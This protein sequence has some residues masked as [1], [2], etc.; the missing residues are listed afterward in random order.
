MA[1]PDKIN[2]ILDGQVSNNPR[3]FEE[4]GIRADWTTESS[5]AELNVDSLS[6]V[7]D[8]NTFLRNWIMQGLSGGVGIYE[9]VPIEIEVSDT[10]NSKSVFK[11]YVDLTTATFKG[12]KE[13]SADVKKLKGNT[14]I[15]EVANPLS[16]ASLYDQGFIT[17]AMTVYVPTL[18]N[19]VPDGVE[20]SILSITLFIM[21]KELYELIRTLSNRI[22]ELIATFTPDVVVGTAAEVAKPGSIAKEILAA[23]FELAYAIVI[24]IAIIKLIKEIINQLYPP[25]RYQAGILVKDLVSAACDK[26][27]MSFSSTIFD[28]APF[29]NMV[30][31]GFKDTK[32]NKTRTGGQSYPTAQDQVYTFGDLI[33]VLQSMFNAKY[34]ITDNVFYLERRDF[35]Q[36]QSAYQLPDVLSNFDERYDE[37]TYNANDIQSNYLISFTTDYQDQNTLDN[38]SGTNYQIITS[39]NTVNDVDYVNIKNLTQVRLPIS[40]GIRK[41]ELT[42]FE[43]FLRGLL[44]FVDLL[45]G[46]FGQGSNFASKVQGR[47]GSLNLSQ[48]LIG[49]NKFLIMQGGKISSQN[50]TVLSAKY[51]WENYH[52][53]ESFAEINGTHNQ[54]KE[55]SDVRI[56]FS[57]ND[58]ISLIGNNFFTTSNG[59]EGE[60][61]TLDWVADENSAVVSYRIKEKFTNNLKLEFIEGGNS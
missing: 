16:F 38:F 41:S 26:L 39:A 17:D 40:R 1:K 45:T 25:V 19:Y 61:R 55:Y 54:Y 12:E 49:N 9:G 34:K 4:I 7:N 20:L 36:S 10:D 31:L 24:V 21:G 5:E 37:F 56:P 50:E 58:F 57:F 47:I 35:W 2:F 11:G 32:G 46:V 22:G 59:Q 3:E 30:F 14:W 48:E 42:G 29:N 13:L 33:R 6:F 15:E 52:Y 53:I 23:I 43:K 44:Q 60:I 8:E 28:N 51:L 27:N 18:R